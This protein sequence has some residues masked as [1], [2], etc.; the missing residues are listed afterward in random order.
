MT[1]AIPLDMGPMEP[2]SAHSFTACS[3]S[4]VYIPS[5]MFLSILS[6]EYK[7]PECEQIFQGEHAPRPMGTEGQKIQFT[8]TNGASQQR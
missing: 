4:M 5:S 8:C 2:K 7:I 1:A 3:V 6:C